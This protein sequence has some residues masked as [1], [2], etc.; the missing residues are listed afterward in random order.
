MVGR[1]VEKEITHTGWA[2]SGA[3]SPALRLLG[4][5]PWLLVTR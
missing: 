3:G 5:A 2:I 4:A 1:R